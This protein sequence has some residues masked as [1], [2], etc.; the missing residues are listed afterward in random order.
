[1]P[2]SKTNSGSVKV[3][4]RTKK[5]VAN[6]VAVGSISWTRYSHVHKFDFGAEN[7]PGTLHKLG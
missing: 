5:L 2:D 7:C 6:G 4:I 3:F 1:M